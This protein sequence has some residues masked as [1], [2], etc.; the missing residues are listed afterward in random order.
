M[1]KA[2]RELRVVNLETREV[3]HRVDISSKTDRMV[4]RC[5]MGMLRNMSDAYYIQDSADDEAPDGE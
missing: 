1:A 3:V 5:M 4:E 2:K